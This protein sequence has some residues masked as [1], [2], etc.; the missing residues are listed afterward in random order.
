MAYG[1]TAT[2]KAGQISSAQSNF[3]WLATADN[4]PTAAIDGGANSILNGGGDLRCY[5][6]STKTTQLPIEVVSFVTGG[7]PNVIVWG[8]SPSLN[9]ASTVYFEKDAAATAQPIATD[10]Y[11]RNAVWAEF[12]CVI[13]SGSI[14]DSTGNNTPVLNGTPSKSA[15]AFSEGYQITSASEYISVPD[16]AS[17][18]IEKDFTALGWLSASTFITGAPLFSKVDGTNTDGS[19]GFINSTGKYRTRQPNLSPSNLDSSATLSTSTDYFLSSSFDGTTRK[20]F[21]DGAFDNSDTP[22]GTVNNNNGDYELGRAD[23]GFGLRLQG[24]IG[25]NWLAIPALSDIDNRIEALYNNQNSPI[26]FWD[27][28]AWED[29]GG[30]TNFTLDLDGGVFTYSGDSISL[31]LD[32]AISTNGAIYNYTGSPV[33]LLLDRLVAID[34]ANYSYAGGIVDAL[35]NRSIKTDGAI[36]NYSGGALD[37]VYSQLTNYQLDI[38]GGIF[39]YS[40]SSINLINDRA[41]SV[42]GTSFSYDGSNVTFVYDQIGG[43]SLNIEGA[44]YSYSGGDIA[45]TYNRLLSISGGMY[46][47]TGGELTNLYDR[48]I[49]TNGANYSYA[50]GDVDVLYGRALPITGANYSYDGGAVGLVYSGAVTL[51]IDGYSV[52]FKQDDFSTKYQDDIARINYGSVQ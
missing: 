40:G 1:F 16:S 48:V 7:T 26:L 6:D 27:S 50:G 5:T 31:L 3:T 9:V 22:S 52:Q 12:I 45:T 32:R 20:C 34:G 14:V 15:I 2:V 42:D 43:Y 39:T 21:V 47:Y 30:G 44:T 51:L 4:F 17:L 11:G 18:D 8:V 49:N 41:L 35:F 37:L 46:S 23:N 28:S 38:D 10:T 13:H 24:I 33:D 25:E 29:Q 36:Y 19:F